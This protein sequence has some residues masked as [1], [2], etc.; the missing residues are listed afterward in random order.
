MIQF[1]QNTTWVRVQLTLSLCAY[2]KNRLKVEG[3]L[4]LKLKWNNETV[5]TEVYVVQSK[6]SVRLLSY[7]TAVDLGILSLNLKF[8]ADDTTLLRC[9]KFNH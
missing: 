1:N 5:Q 4:K 9:Y 8:L 7:Y 3:K 6:K 2:G